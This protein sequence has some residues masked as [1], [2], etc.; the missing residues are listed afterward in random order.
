MMLLDARVFAP[1]DVK[2][3]K[4]ASFCVFL[5]PFRMLFIIF[6]IQNLQIR[7]SLRSSLIIPFNYELILNSYL[8]FCFIY[9]TF[10]IENNTEKE[11]KADRRVTLNEIKYQQQYKVDADN[12]PKAAQKPETQFFTLSREE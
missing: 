12:K 3:V 5:F 11:S 10:G 9:D 7:G 6:G 2:N 8:L 4:I 1:F